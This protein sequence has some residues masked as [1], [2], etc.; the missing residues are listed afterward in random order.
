VALPKKSVLRLIYC[1]FNALNLHNFTLNSDFLGKAPQ[2]REL[3]QDLGCLGLTLAG[4]LIT[5][6]Q[7]KPRGKELTDNQKTAKQTIARRRVRSE[8]IICRVNRC[9]MVKDTIRMWKETARDLV[10][11]VCCGLHN[12]RLRLHPWP[13]LSK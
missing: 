10:M 6:P 5:Q 3:L 9:R 7:K 4:I 13:A 8:Q 2:G 12:V 11:A 1:R